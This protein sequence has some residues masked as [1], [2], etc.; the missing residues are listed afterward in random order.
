VQPGIVNW[1]VAREQLKGTLSP[2]QI[3]WLGLFVEEEAA[4]VRVGHLQAR[5]TAEFRKRSK[6]K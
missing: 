6:A 5:L 4:S 2:A 3:E 1:N